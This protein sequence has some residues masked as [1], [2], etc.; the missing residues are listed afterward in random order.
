MVTLRRD[1]MWHFLDRLI[2]LAIP[3][4][5]DFRG[6]KDSSFDRGGCYSMGLTEQAVWPEIYPTAI[7]DYPRIDRLVTSLLQRPAVKKVHELHMAAA[8]TIDRTG[9][10]G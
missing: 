1:R 3:R 5:K 4:I 10:H 6:L 2:N 7:E 9:M 8:K